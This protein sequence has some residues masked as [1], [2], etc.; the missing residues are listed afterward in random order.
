MQAPDESSTSRQ[1][2]ERWVV[3]IF[4]ELQGNYGTRFLSQWQTGQALP[5]GRDAGLVNAMAMWARKL[6]GF[7][8]QHQAIR[9]VLDSLPENPPSLPEFV[10]LCREAARR[11]TASAPRLGHKPTAEDKARA[12]EAAKRVREATNSLNPRKDQLAWAKR[13]NERYVRGEALPAQAELMARS[14]M[15]RRWQEREGRAA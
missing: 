4:S 7:S 11:L 15:G 10:S 2:P 1:L 5:D 9:S 6:G 14:A 12:E 8:D 3:K 13:L